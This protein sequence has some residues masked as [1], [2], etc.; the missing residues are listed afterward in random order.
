[1]DTLIQY[2]NTVQKN[3]KKYY[4]LSNTQSAKNTEP[5]ISDRLILDEQSDQYLWLRCG[6]D[7]KRRVQHIILY[8]QIHNGKIWVEED[9]TNLAI[10]DDLLAAGIPQTDIILGF[11]HPSKRALTEFAIA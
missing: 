5:T 7:G 1:M 9:S 2:R 10:V 3:L 6:W 4:E 11:H 8:L